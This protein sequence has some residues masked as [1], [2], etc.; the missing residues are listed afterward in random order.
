MF[1]LKRDHIDTIRFSK[2]LSP[3]VAEGLDDPTLTSRSAQDLSDADYDTLHD[4]CIDA[5][6]N[7][8]PVVKQITGL[9]RDEDPFHIIIR[10][11]PGVYFV[12]AVEFDDKGIFA[13]FDDAEAWV[14]SYY[15]P[16]ITA[17]NA[18]GYGCDC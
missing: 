18:A 10:G 13:S 3:A 4:A 8:A 16:F 2:E 11:I 7:D 6:M 12:S 17:A 5:L 14:E 1:Q 15:E 9:G